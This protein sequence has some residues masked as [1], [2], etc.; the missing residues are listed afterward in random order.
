MIRSAGVK[1][2]KAGLLT[3]TTRRSFQSK[4]LDGSD[5]ALITR[6]AGKRRRLNEDDG[7]KVR[8]CLLNRNHERGYFGR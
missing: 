3:S 7:I 8:K 6:R 2:L 5:L 1:R 4:P